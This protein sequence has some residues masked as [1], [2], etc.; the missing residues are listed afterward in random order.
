L[1]AHQKRVVLSFDQHQWSFAWYGYCSMK[2][3][4]QIHSKSVGTLLQ[5]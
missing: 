4:L 3:Q 2:D 5:A 1:P